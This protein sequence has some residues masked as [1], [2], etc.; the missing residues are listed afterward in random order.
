MKL[1]GLLA[2]LRSPAPFQH[3]VLRAED[4]VPGAV[5]LSLPDNISVA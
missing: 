4:V 3:C 2:G 1:Y 5:S